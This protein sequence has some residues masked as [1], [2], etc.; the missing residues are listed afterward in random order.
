MKVSSFQSFLDTATAWVNLIGTFYG[1]LSR[2]FVRALMLKK[3]TILRAVVD[4]RRIA[5]KRIVMGRPTAHVL[6]TKQCVRRARWLSTD[7]PQ[8]PTLAGVPVLPNGGKDDSI[9][10]SQR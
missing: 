9:R 3:R 4:D 2:D 5:L 8:S 1:I 7:G 10:C 6:Q